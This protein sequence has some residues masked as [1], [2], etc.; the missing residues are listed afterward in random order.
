MEAL[1]HAGFHHGSA[2]STS[3]WVA[4]DELVGTATDERAARADGILVPGGFGVRGVEGKVEAI[5]FARERAHPVPGALPRP[6]VRGDR[7]RAQRLRPG[8]RQLLRVRPGHAA[9]RDRPAAR[10]A[11]RG[12][13]GGDRCGWAR[14]PCYLVAGHAGRGGV[15]RGRRPRAPP[16]PLG[17]QPR[18]TTRSCEEHGMVFSG[19]SPD[20]PAGRDH[21][22]AR[23]SVLRGRP[24][25]PRAEVAARPGRIR[26]SGTFVGAARVARAARPHAPAR[27][28][29]AGSPGDAT[30]GRPARPEPTV[31]VV[32]EGATFRVEVEDWPQGGAARSS[33][34]RAPCAVVPL[35]TADDGACWCASS[36]PPVRQVLTGDP[37]RASSTWRARTPADCAAP[38]AA[39]GDRPPG[40][41]RSS[42]LGGDLHVSPGF[43][44][45]RDRPVRG[46]ASSRAR[47]APPED[48]IE[49]VTH[50]AGRDAVA[51]ARDGTDPD[52]KTRVRA[53][54]R[55]PGTSGYPRADRARRLP[56]RP[57]KEVTLVIVGVPTEVKDNEYRVA[58]DA[59]G[60]PRADPR[61]S[62]RRARRTAR[63]TGSSIPQDRYERAG[64]EIVAER[65]GRLRRRPT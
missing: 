65:R 47:A 19:M 7:V 4:S 2:T 17:G 5:R 62:P 32:F 46:R 52:A 30:D 40:R 15:R 38:R 6:A 8:R 9:P 3:T 35:L 34:T 11:R 54:A 59:R 18:R 28:P 25:P 60:R 55:W 21:R 20:G 63:A 43:T 48:G 23:P 31:E 44:D 29:S 27:S 53:A 56:G 39:R 36:A 14:Y 42:P 37:G 16:P 50:A 22:A 13:H 51:A 26:C 45:E 33:T 10:A 49:V 57:R 64:A 1:Q 41:S 61:R 24:V 12:R 58:L